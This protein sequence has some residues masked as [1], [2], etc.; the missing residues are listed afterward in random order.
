MTDKLSNDINTLKEAAFTI[1]SYRRAALEV[2]IEIRRINQ[3]F[4]ETVFNPAA[5]EMLRNALKEEDMTA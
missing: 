3:A 2:S 4:G 1:R 5:T